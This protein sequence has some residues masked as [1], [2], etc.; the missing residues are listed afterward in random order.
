MIADSASSTTLESALPETVPGYPM[1]FEMTP[2]EWNLS[3]SRGT[4]GCASGQSGNRS[5]RALPMRL[6]P[7]RNVT[8]SHRVCWAIRQFVSRRAVGFFG[9]S[10]IGFPGPMRTY[11]SKMDAILRSTPKSAAPAKAVGPSYHPLTGTTAYA[12]RRRSD[13]IA[14]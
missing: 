4:P 6:G 12:D 13:H 3:Q 7:F 1:T 10:I 11:A 9:A 8:E 5:S 14:R 2:R